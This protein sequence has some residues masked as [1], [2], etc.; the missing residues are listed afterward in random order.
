ML[1]FWDPWFSDAGATGI[2]F[3]RSRVDQQAAGDRLPVHAAHP[4]SRSPSAT[5]TAS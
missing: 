5:R 4:D 3:A 2:S 1:G